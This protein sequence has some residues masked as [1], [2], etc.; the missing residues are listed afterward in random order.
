[1]AAGRGARLSAKP[2]FPRDGAGRGQWRRAEAH[3][4]A[5]LPWVFEAAGAFPAP[6]GTPAVRPYRSDAAPTRRRAPC[7]PP[8]ARG[9]CSRVECDKS[10]EDSKLSRRMPTAVEW[11]AGEAKPLGGRWR[12]HTGRSRKH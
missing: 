11:L 5:E 1:M 8:A 4:G 10:I 2:V 6:H 12:I 9:N 7:P 3:A